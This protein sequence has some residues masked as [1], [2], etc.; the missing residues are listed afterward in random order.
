MPFDYSPPYI[1]QITFVH[2]PMLCHAPYKVFE[3]FKDSFAVKNEIGNQSPRGPRHNCDLRLHSTSKQQHNPW[4]TCI[5]PVAFPM[6][7]AYCCLGYSF[8]CSLSI[9]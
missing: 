5:A 2:Y 8:K 4:I 7:F 6:A 1:L 3:H 9:A